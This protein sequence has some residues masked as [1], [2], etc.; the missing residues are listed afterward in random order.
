MANDGEYY[1]FKHYVL[2][3]CT[4][5]RTLDIKPK[6]FI[7]LTGEQDNTTP[8]TIETIKPCM[9]F[10][11]DTMIFESSYQG[12]NESKRSIKIKIYCLKYFFLPQELLHFET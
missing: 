8:S 11:L 5:N 7:I 1:S 3:C 6:L 2:E 9:S 10:K 12:E 4:T